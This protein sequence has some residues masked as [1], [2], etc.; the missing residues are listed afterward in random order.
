MA[1]WQAAV[2]A[3][4]VLAT[5]T[6]S[7]ANPSTPCCWALPW[8]HGRRRNSVSCRRSSFLLPPPPPPLTDAPAPDPSPADGDRDVDGVMGW[9]SPAPPPMWCVARS[10]SAAASYA[11]LLYAPTIDTQHRRSEFRPAS[12]H[13]GP[14]FN[15]DT[16]TTHTDMQSKNQ[17]DTHWNI[18]RASYAVALASHIGASS[19]RRAAV[20]W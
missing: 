3:V 11:C 8:I 12:I 19:G 17:H 5:P 10:P 14:W 2:P 20:P 18:P 1:T 7:M 6:V 9:S 4:L 13:R 16:Q 15:K